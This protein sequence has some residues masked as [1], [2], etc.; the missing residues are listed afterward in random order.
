MNPTR[1]ERGLRFD[2][3]PP[4]P[5]QATRHL[6]RYLIDPEGQPL[7]VN[8]LTADALKGIG[9]MGQLEQLAKSGD[10]RAAAFVTRLNAYLGQLYRPITEDRPLTAA[11]QTIIDDFR[12]VTNHANAYYHLCARPRITGDVRPSTSDLSASTD[13][14]RERYR[15]IIHEALAPRRD[16]PK[17]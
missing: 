14:R 12:R 9:A 17:P 11:E 5:S 4:N 6:I 1:P 10:E 7:P 8:D 15:S 2:P 16:K 3:S 13:E